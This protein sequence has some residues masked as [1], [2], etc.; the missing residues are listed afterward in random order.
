VHNEEHEQGGEHKEELSGELL[1]DGD[2]AAKHPGRLGA[3]AD[4]LAHCGS[5]TG[6]F[7]LPSRVHAGL[8]GARVLLL[9]LLRCLGG[10][11]VAW[12]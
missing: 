12:I 5:V 2:R 7:A 4:E 3:R 8:F 1:S 9:L 11:Y 10:C 6:R